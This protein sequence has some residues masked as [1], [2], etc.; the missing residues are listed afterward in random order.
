MSVC[1]RA[2]RSIPRSP[3]LSPTMPRLET[4]WR[5]ALHAQTLGTQITHAHQSHPRWATEGTC[6]PNRALVSR[7]GAVSGRSSTLS[8]RK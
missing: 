2:F 1:R 7:A 5:A 3:S 6:V 4:P 8:V